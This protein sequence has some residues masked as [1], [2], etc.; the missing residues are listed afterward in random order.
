M[1]SVHALNRVCVSIHHVYTKC[2]SDSL[3]LQD[4]VISFVVAALIFCGAA[5]IGAYSGAWSSVNPITIVGSQSGLVTSTGA[6][7][8]SSCMH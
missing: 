3:F 4:I 6:T 8:V 2:I 1:N 5:A 7:S